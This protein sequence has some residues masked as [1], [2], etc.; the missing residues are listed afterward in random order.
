[1]SDIKLVTTTTLVLIGLG[2]ST[3]VHGLI[4]TGHSPDVLPAMGPASTLRC[5]QWGVLPVAVCGVKAITTITSFLGLG[6]G[7]SHDGLVV[8]ASTSPVCYW[9]LVPV[10]MRRVRIISTITWYPGLGIGTSVDGLI[11]TGHSPDVLPAMSPPPTSYIGQ[12][13]GLPV[14]I[15]GVRA[16]T[17]ITSFLGQGLGTIRHGLVVAGHSPGGLPGKGLS[18]YSFGRLLWL[19]FICG[20][21]TDDGIRIP[22]PNHPLRLVVD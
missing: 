21:V 8:A 10:A 16:I 2:V 15:C 6:L 11:L 22:C 19:V 14:V 3:S 9:G 5:G 13:R 17:T 18:S 12:W 4:P 7:T 20:I 1:L